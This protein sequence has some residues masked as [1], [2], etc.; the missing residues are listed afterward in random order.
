MTI[1]IGHICLLIA[2]TGIVL[3]VHPGLRFNIAGMFTIGGIFGLLTGIAQ[4]LLFHGGC[5]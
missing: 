2:L 1:I 4:L 3:L 5:S